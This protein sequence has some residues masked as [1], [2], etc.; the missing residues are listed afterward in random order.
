MYATKLN[1]NII[2]KIYKTN[3][4]SLYSRNINYSIFLITDDTDVNKLNL[5][6]YFKTYLNL[7]KKIKLLCLIKIKN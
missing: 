4:Y 3:T 7:L 1:A 2:V 6:Y 5:F